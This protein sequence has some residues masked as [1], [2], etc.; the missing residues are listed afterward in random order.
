LRSKIDN[1][2]IFIL[3][4]LLA[5]VM[6]IGLS[7]CSKNT[8]GSA[9]NVKVIR[10][11]TTNVM[12]PYTYVDS[13]GNLVGFE[14][15]FISAL[16]KRLPQYKFE[17]QT[18]QFASL[19]VSLQTGKLD[20]AV[21]QF[22]KNPQRSKNFLIPDENY[23]VSPLRIAVREDSTINSLEDLRGKTIIMD[24]TS[25]EYGYVK[26]FSDQDPSHPIN[27]QEVQSLNDAD[28]LKMVASGRLDADLTYPTEF[29]AIQDQL[30]LNL[31]LAPVV[32]LR[33]LT[34]PLI[35][36]QDTQLDQDVNAQIKA[37]KADGTLSQLAI[38]WFKED[39]FKE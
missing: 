3:L 32:V 22:V 25:F 23:C 31:K 2:P 1:K 30:H 14:E 24:P 26:A 8:S 7:G 10:V 33:E 4:M 35:A 12:P 38:K 20:M 21:N 29:N 37:M 9:S 6:I 39:V 16:Q 17:I 11:G 18:M 27:I 34:Y 28:N 5:T 13:N 19:A 36:K 15:D